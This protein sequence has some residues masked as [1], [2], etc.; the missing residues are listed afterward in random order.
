M[1][2]VK[3]PYI[4]RGRLYLGSDQKIQKG[5]FIPALLRLAALALSLIAG[6]GIKKEKKERTLDTEKGFEIKFFF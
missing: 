4:K 1:K 3:K 5:G 2:I 6:K